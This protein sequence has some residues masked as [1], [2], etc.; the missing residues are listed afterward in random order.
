VFLCYESITQPQKAR[1][2]KPTWGICG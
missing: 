1:Y 2:S